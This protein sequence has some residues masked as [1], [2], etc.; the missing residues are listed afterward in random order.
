MA[1]CGILI[2]FNDEKEITIP[3]MK[4]GTGMMTAKMF[5]DN[6]GKIIS[7]TIHNGGFIGTHCHETSDDINYV[8]SGEGKAICDGIEEILT[9][10]F[11]HIC[12]KGN[13]HSII[14]TGID[15]LV[16]LTNSY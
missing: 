16:L 7:C 10:G 6:G 14:N 5:I 13:E 15:D 8:L 1:R 9:A 3:C 4:N 11:C 2:N 12:K